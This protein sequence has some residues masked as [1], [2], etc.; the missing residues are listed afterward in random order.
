VNEFAAQHPM[1]AV[2]LPK[3]VVVLF[4][5]LTALAYLTWFERKVVAHI[6]ARWGPYRVGPHGL[7]Q[8]LAD[9][10]K[11]LFKEDP[12]PAGADK[13]AYFLAPFLALSLA[14][15]SIAVIP[16]G[17]KEFKIFGQSTPLAITNLN[18]GLLILFAITSMGVYGVA[19]AGWSSNSKYPLMGGLRSSAQMV[20]YELALTMSV[21]G[22]ILM[23][24]TFNLSEIVLSQQGF[25]WG[26]VPRWNLIGAP[27]PQV[28]G[29][30]LFFA[31][32]VAETN[33]APFDLAE[34][35]SELV[36]GFH[37]EYASFKFAMFFMA[38]YSSMITVSC[39]ATILFF[40]GWLSPFPQTALWAWTR[41]IPSA[42]FALAG[43]ALIV[44]GVR[45][46]TMFGR[47]VLPALGLILCALGLLFSRPGVPEFIQG[48]FWFLLKIVIFLF[49]Y[50][51]VRGT[52]PRF[53]Y[54]Q[55]MNFG[56]KL[57]LPLSILNVVITSLAIVWTQR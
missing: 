20:S 56:W 14:I 54:D 26:F 41:Y 50:V 37:T 38:E 8:P 35:E 13:F 31:A 24:G 29:F 33:R 15:T 6:Q 52:L 39:L 47:I 51:W 44:H 27:M 36:G 19:L 1:L 16:F 49:V 32:A 25:H 10:L 12:T 55:L 48:P 3:I 11:F 53:R 40:G 5:L 46:L 23:A 30:L 18:I 57:L 2:A 45:Y 22:V 28:L 43:L 7:L 17:P 34:A 4:V 9:G 21:V 42:G